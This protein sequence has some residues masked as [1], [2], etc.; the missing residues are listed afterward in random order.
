MIWNVGKITGYYKESNF[1][2]ILDMSTNETSKVFIPHRAYREKKIPELNSLFAY[3]RYSS[4]ISTIEVFDENFINLYFNE[5]HFNLMFYINEYHSNLIN[6][7]I[8]KLIF[9]KEKLL[10]ELKDRLAISDIK[11]DHKEIES[12]FTVEVEF[13]ERNKVGDD[14]SAQ[15]NFI[16]S[17]PNFTTSQLTWLKR[18][19]YDQWNIL[20]YRTCSNVD[21]KY[22]L[23]K[24]NSD[25]SKQIAVILEKVKATFRT[26]FTVIDKWEFSGK[27]K[28]INTLIQYKLNE[29]G[30]EHTLAT[31]PYILNSYVLNLNEYFEYNRRLVENNL[32]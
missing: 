15:M 23:E 26:K 11:I 24:R 4:A 20:D 2:D 32:V 9:E 14:Y 21:T 27:C 19:S 3:V 17:H 10:R 8:H 29:N 22:I 18:E 12:S 25:Y 13:H 28:T 16:L 5:L 30:F 1:F 6:G 7:T 31:L